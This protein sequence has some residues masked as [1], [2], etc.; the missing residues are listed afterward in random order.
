MRSQKQEAEADVEKKK[1]ERAELTAESR[2]RNDDIQNLKNKINKAIDDL[3]V[4][5]SH[6]KFLMEVADK[7]V[8]EK[9]DRAREK[10]RKQKE[11][12]EADAQKYYDKKRGTSKDKTQSIEV[13]KEGTDW[14]W[15]AKLKDL[16]EVDDYDMVYPVPF[17]DPKLLMENFS[18]LEEKNL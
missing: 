13:A 8:K 16:F 11:Q 18:N 6:M 1:K 9:F 10:R 3:Q 17:S 7:N 14:K 2:A 4:Y 12:E 15:P 5:E